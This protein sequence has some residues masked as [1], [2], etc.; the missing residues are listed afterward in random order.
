MM[1]HRASFL[2]TVAAA[3]LLGATLLVG[4]P[5]Q[6]AET[7]ADQI[8]A[9][10]AAADADAD[11]AKKAKAQAILADAEADQKS[12]NEAFCLDEVAAAKKALGMN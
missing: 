8:K 5:A 4:A 10:R 9:V 7:C 3:A 2:A 6:A 11:A 1:M 12:G